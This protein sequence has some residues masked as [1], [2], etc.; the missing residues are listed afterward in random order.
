MDTSLRVSAAIAVAG[1]LLALVFV[2]RVKLPER[3]DE[4]PVTGEVAT[5]AR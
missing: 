5:S 3:S 4:A 1:F 2:P